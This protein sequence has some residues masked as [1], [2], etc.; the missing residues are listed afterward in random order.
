MS[1]VA[2]EHLGNWARCLGI[3][4]VCLI[5]I[6]TDLLAYPVWPLHRD[7]DPPQVEHYASAMALTLLLG[8]SIWLALRLNSQMWVRAGLAA[9]VTVLAVKETFLAVTGLGVLTR[10]SILRPLP[11]VLLGLASVLVMAILKRHTWQRTIVLTGKLAAALIPLTLLTFGQSL[12]RC[13]AIPPPS[14]RRF[15]TEAKAGPRPRRRV[16]WIILDELD[17]RVAFT[18][19]RKGVRLPELE[20]YR[21]EADFV[22]L[23]ARSPAN[24]TV[25]SLPALLGYTTELDAGDSVFGQVRRMGKRS[26]IAGWAIPYCHVFRNWTD[27]CAWWPMPQQHNSLPTSGVPAMAASMLISLFETNQLSPFGQSQ[28]VQRFARMVEEATAEGARLAARPDLDFVFLHLPPPHNPY[29]FNPA[30]GKID[31]A[32]IRFPNP[33]GYFN[34]LLL[35][36]QVFGRIRR[37]ME[38]SG[39]WRNSLVLVTADHGVRSGVPL[40]YPPDDQHVPFMI[41]SPDGFPMDPNAPLAT[42][43]T[44]QL[45]LNWLQRPGS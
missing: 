43:R 23:N 39:V 41:K 45:L 13:T 1:P 24:A 26:A 15:D 19:P 40:G 12:V 30:T 36:D 35:A 9:F 32:I 21:R 25:V 29:A 11:L 5:R 18:H 44:G 10:A 14:V 22:G 37:A 7:Y 4:N 28:S 27:A 8:T 16:V 31:K 3:A 6:W 33:E 38:R 17:E 20:R 34:N 2:R 42:E